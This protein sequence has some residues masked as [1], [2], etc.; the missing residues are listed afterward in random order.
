MTIAWSATLLCAFMSAR[1]A[2][3][4]LRHNPR[5]FTAMA[6]FAFTWAH[7]LGYYITAPDSTAGNA[8]ADKLSD[9]ITDLASFLFV[10]IGGLLFLDSDDDAKKATVSVLQKLGLVFLLF[11]I[12]PKSC[13]FDPQGEILGL[14][15]ADLK[16]G[17]ST[18]LLLAGYASVALGAY[19]IAGPGAFT[20]LAAIL[21]VYA[22]SEL[23]YTARCWGGA[24]HIM[25]PGFAYLF[26]GLKLLFAPVFGSIVAFH[27]MTPDDR[28]RGPRYWILHFFYLA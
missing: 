11:I 9:L 7:V 6:L 23:I 4:Y 3:A 5:L 28:K 19:G 22:S 12:A 17:V 16:Q 24:C 2:T 26:A 21:V 18:A 1:F 15:V 14:T 27:G 13:A 20:L 8:L 10:Y 25:A